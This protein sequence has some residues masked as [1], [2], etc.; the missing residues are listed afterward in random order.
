M[1]DNINDYDANNRT[2]NHAMKI[3]THKSYLISKYIFVEINNEIINF[4]KYILTD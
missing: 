4:N 3:S 1:L 2:Y